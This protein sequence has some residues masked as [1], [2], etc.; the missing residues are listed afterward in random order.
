MLSIK[1][2]RQKYP[3]YEDLSDEQLVDALHSK[4]YSDMPKE[5]FHAKIG[6]NQ[7]QQKSKGFLRNALDYEKSLGLGSLQG[8]GDVGASILN[9]PIEGAEKLSGRQLPHVPHPKLQQYYPEGA[10]GKVGSTIGE[11]LGGFAVPG[12]AF[13]KALKYAPEAKGLLKTLAR[14]G[15]GAGEGALTGAAVSEGNRGQGAL[16]GGGLGA[17]AQGVSKAYKSAREFSPWDKF[18]SE[19]SPEE[20]TRNLKLAEGTETGLGNIIESPWLQR[21]HENVLPH[22]IGSGAEKTMLKNASK[23]SEK[24]ESLLSKARGGEEVSE[25]YGQKIKAALQEAHQK[26]EQEKNA[27]FNKVNELAEKSGIGTQRKHL[28]SEAE[29]ILKQIKSDPDLAKFTNSSDIKLIED[30]ARPG[31]KVAESEGKGSTR[32]FEQANEQ[33]NYHGPIDIGTGNPSESILNKSSYSV[34]RPTPTSGGR[35]NV[36]TGKPIEEPHNYSL[37]NTDILR[38][39]IGENAYEA[40]VKGE[41]PKASI[42]SRLKKALEQDVD[43]AIESSSN[44]ELKEARKSAME[45]YKTEFAPFKDKDITKF[46]KEGGD[47]DLI[48]S[49]FLKTGTNDRAMLLQKLSLKTKSPANILAH[50]YL[51]PAYKNGQ[52]DPIKLSALYH[53][54]GPNQRKELFGLRFNEQLKDYTDLVHKNREAFGLMFNPKTGARLGHIGSVAGAVGSGAHAIPG[55]IATGV[56]GKLAN[57]ALT[58]PVYRKKIVEAIIKKK[59]KK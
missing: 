14:M 7:P 22:V 1:E 40:H 39:K 38:S 8:L 55:L 10:A 26:V 11:V 18:K 2:I 30:I 33:P 12:G 35:I 43:E 24:G 25:N 28:R 13:G 23:I 52:L 53:K 16:I 5:E 56:A 31:K 9:F 46:I 49:H 44:K 59:Q 27:N 57:K 19:L 45:H 48:L 34:T 36:I 6:F 50:A 4:H 32:T 37:K 47:P 58:S 41:K 51:S 42:Y 29:S 20:L 15:I 3:D 54:L 21:L 17:G